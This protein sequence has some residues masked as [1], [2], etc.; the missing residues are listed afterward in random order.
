MN[1]LNLTKSQTN[2]LKS[3]GI[4]TDEISHYKAGR[5]ERI[6]KKRLNKM[7]RILSEK[8]KRSSKPFIITVNEIKL[9]KS[10][11]IIILN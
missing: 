5:F 6:G 9:R 3:N 8:K 4:R 2:K 11:N 1:E 7:K 10:T